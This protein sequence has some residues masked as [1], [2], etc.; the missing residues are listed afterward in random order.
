MET[1][2]S[3]K[4]DIAEIRNQE[5]NSDN[6]LVAELKKSLVVE[7]TARSEL[8]KDINEMRYSSVFK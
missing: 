1:T 7:Q 5:N 3:L 8:Q 6:E 4:R 2:A